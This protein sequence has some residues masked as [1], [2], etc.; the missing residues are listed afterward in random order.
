MNYKPEG[1]NSVSPYF[2]VSEAQRFINLLTDIFDAKQRR[3]YERSDGSIMHAELQIDDSIIML[4]EASEEYPSNQL[5]V[6]IYVPD[7]FKTFKKAIKNGCEPMEEPVNKQ[8]DPDT[9]GMFKDYLGNVWAIGMQTKS[10]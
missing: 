10:E 6:H 2:V 4:G 7:V 3:R 9:R 1:Y 5:L 8:E